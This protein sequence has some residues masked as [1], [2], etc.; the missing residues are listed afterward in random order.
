MKQYNTVIIGGGASGLL[1]AITL[2]DKDSILLEK[3]DILG[4][5]ILITGGGRCNITNTNTISGYMKKYYDNPKFYRSAFSNFFNDDIIRL[6]ENY[7][8]QTK[9]EEDGCVFTKNDD[10][11]EVS[12]SLTIA[13]NDSNTCYELNA[14]VKSINKE[15]DFF[16]IE[17]NNKIITAENVILA[18]GGLSYPETG[19]TGDGL[20][21]AKSLGHNPTDFMPGLSP[22]IVK[23]DWVSKLQGITVTVGITIKADKKK[24]VKTRGS[25]LFTSYGL[26]G[27]IILDNSMIIKENLDKDKLVTINLDLASE[28]SYEELDKELM[29]DFSKHPNQMIRTYLQKY[30]PHNMSPVIL[31]AMGIDDNIILNQVNKKTRAKIRDNLKRLSL[32]AID[33]ESKE[34]RVT[35]SG[36]K[37]SEINPNTTESKIVENLYIVGELIEGC[38]FCGGYNLQAA[39]STGVLAANSIKDKKRT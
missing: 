18:T 28:Y 33:I 31:E 11:H 4:R 30:V 13:L 34:S 3:N 35:A 23:E 2:N 26:T 1:A 39:Y 19:S 37:K 12:K 29:E 25:V 9:I 38:G 20:E 7:G 14:R 27:S 22:V 8:C 32:Q 10:A 21:F 5:K 17:Y 24:L 6:L 16:K 15:N 36:I